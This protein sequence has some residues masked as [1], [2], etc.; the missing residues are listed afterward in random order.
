MIGNELI[1]ISQHLMVHTY[2]LH[3]QCYADDFKLGKI[4]LDNI[5]GWVIGQ[6]P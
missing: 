1:P 2:M 3:G 5:P 6:I 4:K